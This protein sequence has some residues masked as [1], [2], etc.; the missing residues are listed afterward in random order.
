M[1]IIKD[2]VNSALDWNR[3]GRNKA[4]RKKVIDTQFN[5]KTRMQL[6]KLRGI[7]YCQ[8]SIFA[9][10]EP[11]ILPE[12]ISLVGEKYKHNELYQMLLAVVPGLVSVVDRKAVL[13]QSR[14]ENLARMKALEYENARIEDELGRIESSIVQ[15]QRKL[16]GKKR[17][18]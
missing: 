7:D 5:S 13:K 14:A 6:C 2:H 15:V 18:R 10:I 16:S 1:L 17:C 3:L 11:I 8:S 9:E 12:A 4:I